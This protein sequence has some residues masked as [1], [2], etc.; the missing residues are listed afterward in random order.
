M[1]KFTLIWLCLLIL[2]LTACNTAETSSSSTE[3]QPIDTTDTMEK[4]VISTEVVE[5]PVETNSSQSEAETNNT[6][7][8]LSTDQDSDASNASTDEGRTSEN[9]GTESSAEGDETEDIATNLDVVKLE[10]F[11]FSN[12]TETAK[13]GITHATALGRMDEGSMMMVGAA[14]GDFNND[15]WVD[16]FAIG[17]GLKADALFINQRDG[18]FEDMAEMAGLTENHVGS[19]AAVGDYNNDGWLDI[20]VTSFGP[21]GNLGE[22]KNRLYR[23]NGDMT[24]TNMA[25]EA[26]VNF[27][28]AE[29]PDGFG[30][31]FGDYDLDGDLDL[32]V[33]GWRKESKGNR[34]FQNNGDETFTDV[35]DSAGIIDNGIRGFAP[36]FADMDGDFYPEILL[37]ADFGTSEYFINNGD[38]SFTQHT[39]QSHVGQEWSGMGSTVGDF[40][41]DGWLDWYTTAIYDDEDVGRGDGNK[42]YYNQGGHNYIEGAQTAGVDDGGWGW[43]AI[44]VDLNQDGWLDLVETNGWEDLKPYKDELSKVWLSNGDGTFDEVAQSVGFEHVLDG[45][46]LLN[47]DYDHDGDQDVVVTAVNDTLQLY[48]NDLN[49]SNANWLQVS[50]DTTGT[51]L[52]PNGIG[53]IIRIQVGDQ[54]FYRN[55]LACSHYLTQSELVAHF[56]LGS[57]TMVD[58]LQVTWADGSVTTLNDISVNQIITITP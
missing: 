27:S 49:L 5:A 55:M 9:S 45:R 47:F 36:C 24:F 2:L 35:T 15:G 39:T 34:L 51:T 26:G 33:T 23:N 57:E 54:T 13:V 30:A 28:S 43:G 40:N 4:T 29:M 32:F 11:G 52:A 50:L 25:A 18:T 44:A 46:G 3:A 56:G 7:Q 16:L 48:R 6:N 53:S 42:L 20:Y 31:S 37:V 22:G 12:Q 8:R 38:G 1:R 41:N 10:G 21:L 14:A 17:G 58:E 19:G